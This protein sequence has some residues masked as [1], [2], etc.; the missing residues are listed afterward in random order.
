MAEQQKTKKQSFFKGLKKEF[1]KVS[2]PDN[3]TLTKET[4]SVTVISVVTGLIIVALDALIQQG[5]HFL[6]SF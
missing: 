4:I 6:T 5:V 3:K 1:K 2:W